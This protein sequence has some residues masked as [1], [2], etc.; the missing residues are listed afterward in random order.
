M[1]G[2]FGYYNLMDWWRDSFTDKEKEQLKFY[3][4]NEENFNEL[5]H[6]HIHSCSQSVVGFLQV[7]GNNLTRSKKYDLAIKFLNQGKIL[8][9]HGTA[10]DVHFL[11]AG[12]LEYYSKYS[13]YHNYEKLVEYAKKQIEISAV[14]AKEIIDERTSYGIAHTGYEIYSMHLKAINATEEVKSIIEKA[15]EEKWNYNYWADELLEEL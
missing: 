14:A 4:N 7:M 12:F 2:T 3:Y 13:P 15:K 9:T 5:F 8:K 10:A 1:N 6:G 11:Y